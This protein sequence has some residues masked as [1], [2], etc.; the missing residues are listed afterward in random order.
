[1]VKTM[2]INTALNV[3]VFGLVVSFVWS[4]IMG[5]LNYKQSKA[6]NELKITNQ[7]LNDILA[8]IRFKNAK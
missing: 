4:I 2:E 7:L 8:E 3:S 6:T 5:W 1:M